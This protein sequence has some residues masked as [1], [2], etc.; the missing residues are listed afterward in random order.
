MDFARLAQMPSARPGRFRWNAQD[1]YTPRLITLSEAH[2]LDGSS[3]IS[4]DTSE[5][6]DDQAA[7][8]LRY[9]A[10]ITKV[11]LRSLHYEGDGCSFSFHPPEILKWLTQYVRAPG[12]RKD[13]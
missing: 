5:R 9:E 11:T 6:Y 2:A 12:L 1:N 10:Y 8:L 13:H 4:I 7:Q 3:L